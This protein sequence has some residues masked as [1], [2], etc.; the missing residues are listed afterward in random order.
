[1]NTHL[2]TLNESSLQ[3]QEHNEQAEEKFKD[4]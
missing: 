4:F 3:L 1:M 2:H